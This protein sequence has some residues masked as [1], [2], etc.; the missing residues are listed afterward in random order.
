ME[1]TG[2][3]SCGICAT[4]SDENLRKEE[5]EK[6]RDY[7]E[8]LLSIRSEYV[9]VVGEAFDYHEKDLFLEDLERIKKRT[10]DEI[11]DKI[12]IENDKG[13][14]SSKQLEKIRKNSD[15]ISQIN[16]GQLRELDMERG[17]D[18]NILDNFVEGYEDHRLRHAFLRYRPEGP[19]TDRS[20]IDRNMREVAEEIFME[21]NMCV[22]GEQ[23][24]N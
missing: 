15:R 13:Y 17:G 18:G 8:E 23:L 6:L 20:T 22:L 3:S 24:K 5:V 2:K 9:G 16:G 1:K 4:Y 12:Q 14:R 11:L 10:D 19:E 7:M 21:R